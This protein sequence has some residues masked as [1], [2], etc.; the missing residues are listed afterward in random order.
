[1]QIFNRNKSINQTDR[2]MGK[3]KY[4][5]VALIPLLIFSVSSCTS[6]NNDTYVPE[7]SYLEGEE[8]QKEG[9]Q[10]LSQ[11]AINE[12]NEENSEKFR[13]V[14]PMKLDTN[15]AQTVDD[16]LNRFSDQDNIRFSADALPLADFLH[17]VFGENLHVSYVIDDDVKQDTKPITFNLTEEI[18]QK[19]LFT[20]TEELL[21]QRQ[22]V[23]RFDDD[24]FYIHKQ[25]KAQGRGNIVF[26]Y[27][28]D[29]SDVP[30]T[31][32]EIVQMVPFEFGIQMSLVN[33]LKQLLGLK[34][35]PDQK[36]NSISLRGKRKDII[37]GLE[38]INMVDKPTVHS[39]DVGMYRSTFLPTQDL[40]DKLT[41]LMA[42]EGL[43]LGENKSTNKVMSVV[44][45]EKQGVIILFASN[46]DIISR[47]VFWLEQIDKPVQTAEKQ[48]FIY[49]PRYS[50]AVD[51][52]ESLEALLGS[53]GN[54]SKSTSAASEN[55][56]G[57]RI[58]SAHS[59]DLKMVVDERA[60]A[61]IFYTTG[62]N[63]QQILPLIKRLDILPK[64]VMLEVMIAE[65][66]L[67]DEF[68]QGVEFALSKG[69]YSVS[70]NG[71]FFG[72][73]FGGLSY[74]LETGSGQLAIQMF[75]SNSLV[76]VLSRPSLVVRDGV[77]ATFNVG[78]QIPIVG[79]TASDPDG[80]RQTTTIE[81]RTTGVKLSVT[82][83]VNAQGVVIMEIDQSISNQVEAGATVASSPSIFE[84]A[85]KT[86]VIA[87]SGQ[88]VILG[89]LI[90][91]NRTEKESRV[92]FFGDLPG[93]GGL[94]RANV[95]AG[96]KTE[97]VVLV[98]PK[99]I[100]SADE[101]QNIKQQ[102]DAGLKEIDI[103]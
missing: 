8:E 48:Y 30:Q 50:R 90:S 20:L 17:Q 91:E 32:A 10:Q 40:V 21:T 55:S 62:Q 68:K 13:F 27:G 9:Q 12:V 64:Q 70:T 74:L 77:A 15:Y 4:K 24:I 95:N 5:K 73:G 44:Q 100:E 35:I 16:I 25:Q 89:G 81:Y 103:N 11:G 92:P 45:L 61:V 96:D 6:I 56:G 22:Y 65:V 66:T 58:R 34:A 39:R 23:I 26:G 7:S 52:G 63:Y 41:E 60:N 102:F 83:T 67:T 75:E 43:E 84:R 101:W 72:D 88:T 36:R 54:L 1:M 76:N 98:T 3:Y 28:K 53:T 49:S 46:Q 69:E 14:P 29:V 82:P 38:L 71:A 80:D 59:K 19:K 78:T 85:I 94:F 33:T 87:N 79:E 97:L 86:E 42:Q 47:A 2:M 37:K 51:M 18:S 93:I 99:I 57:S 31:S